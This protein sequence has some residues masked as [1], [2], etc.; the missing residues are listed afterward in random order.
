LSLCF[1][2]QEAV[3][4][5]GEVELMLHAFLLSAWNI[6]EGTSHLEQETLRKKN[7]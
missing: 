7:T 2:D 4:T 6:S 5:Y 1:A 3:K